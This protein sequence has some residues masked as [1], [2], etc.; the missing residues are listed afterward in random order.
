MKKIILIAALLGGLFI[1]GCKKD[2]TYIIKPMPVVVT[3]LVSFSKD[4]VPL[5]TQ[6]CAV[7]GCH[8]AGGK[9]PVLAADKAFNSLMA[10]TDYINVKSPEDSELYL[11]LTGKKSPAMPMGKA[12][13][14]SNINGLVLAWIKQG[15]KKN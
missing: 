12:T 6:N 2:T 10:N 15:A 1:A 3:K 8:G 11:F 7:A 4:L 9:A 5:F 13:N 14:P